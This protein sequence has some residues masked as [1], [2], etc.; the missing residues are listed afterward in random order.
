MT[1]AK[2]DGPL[3]NIPSRVWGIKYTQIPK[4]VGEWGGG[5]SWLGKYLNILNDGWEMTF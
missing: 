3:Y 2:N 1:T 4:P 5:G